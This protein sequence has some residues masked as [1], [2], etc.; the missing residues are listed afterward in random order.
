MKPPKPY[1]KLREALKSL[2]EVGPITAER[3]VQ[4]LIFNR[5]EGKPYKLIKGVG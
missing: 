1:I 5:E 4:Y 3:L 2:P